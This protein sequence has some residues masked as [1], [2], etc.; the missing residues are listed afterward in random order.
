MAE[1]SSPLAAAKDALASPSNL[2]GDTLESC[3]ARITG[4]SRAEFT[5]FIAQS[6]LKTVYNKLGTL[7]FLP[8]GRKFAVVT[9]SKHEKR[10]ISRNKLRRRAYT[11]L[12]TIN[13]P[14][15]GVLYASKQSYALSNDEVQTH[16]NSL[17]DHAKIAK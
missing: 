8:E 3:S 15:S 10:A 2:K 17:I 13:T 6:G 16:L 9:S 12:Q 1:K 4:F 14:L 5:V 7:K 11:Y